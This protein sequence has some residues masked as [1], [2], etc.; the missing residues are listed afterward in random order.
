M[1]FRDLC[2]PCQVVFVVF[3]SATGPHRSPM[4]HSGF[5]LSPTTAQAAGKGSVC[6]ATHS[7]ETI[8]K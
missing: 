2:F 7:Q 5:E 3:G 8:I 6:G 4:P 1:F